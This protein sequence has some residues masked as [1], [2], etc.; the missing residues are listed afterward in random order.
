[1][2]VLERARAPQRPLPTFYAFVGT[3]DPL[4]DDTRRLARALTQHGVPH[5][6][7]YYPGEVHAFHAL[8]FRRVARDCWRDMLGFVAE[9]LDHG[10]SLRAAG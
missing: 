10:A 7:R 3:K 6:V 1:L 4:L 5:A 8:V 2:L 9:A